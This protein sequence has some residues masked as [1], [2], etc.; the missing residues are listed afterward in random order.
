LPR[1][2]EA[3]A[4]TPNPPASLVLAD[5]PPASWVSAATRQ[6]AGSTSWLAQACHSALAPGVR[7]P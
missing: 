7:P 2:A 5:R 3:P 4:S 1:Q 6:P